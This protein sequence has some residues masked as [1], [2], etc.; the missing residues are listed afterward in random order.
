MEQVWGEVQAIRNHYHELRVELSEAS[1]TPRQMNIIFRVYDDGLG[2]RYELPT[3][4]HL[5]TVE[6][7]DEG[8]RI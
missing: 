8:D 6:I 1:D 4:E 2:F 5:Q 7:M 3:Q